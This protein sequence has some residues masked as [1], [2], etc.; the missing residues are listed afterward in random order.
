[1]ARLHCLVFGIND[2]CSGGRTPV[3][4]RMFLFGNKCATNS[5]TGR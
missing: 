5:A 1:M 3:R 4:A 2:L